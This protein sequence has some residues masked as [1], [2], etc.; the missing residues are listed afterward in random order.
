MAIEQYTK[1]AK[2]YTDK[3]RLHLAARMHTTI[4]ELHGKEAMTAMDTD[5]KRQA[6]LKAME[7]YHLAAEYY[8]SEG[9]TSMK[10]QCHLKVATVN[11]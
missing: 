7:H 1:A 2:I 3:G 6:T 10:N 8:Y 11:A 5:D 9:S 4:G